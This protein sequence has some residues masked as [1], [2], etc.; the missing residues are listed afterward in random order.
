M[1]P[2][3][4]AWIVALLLAASWTA[5][6]F[7]QESTDVTIAGRLFVDLNANGVFDQ[8]ELALGGIPIEFANGDQILTVTSEAD[9]AF[10]IQ[11]EPGLWR[12]ALRPPEGFEYG[13]PEGIEL[14]VLQAEE[15]ALDL[16]IGLQPVQLLQ[17]LVNSLETGADE[18]QPAEEPVPA[19]SGTQPEVFDGP[20]VATPEAVDPNLLPA[21]GSSLPPRAVVVLAAAGGLALGLG[22]WAVGRTLERRAV[23]G[24]EVIS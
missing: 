7:A 14:Q 1:R 24:S 10:S 8:G 3:T 13:L 22:F 18:V 21:S 11:V 17:V 20:F 4:R 6:T 12:A 5:P 16:Q 15:G 23:P 9:G 2:K 19:E